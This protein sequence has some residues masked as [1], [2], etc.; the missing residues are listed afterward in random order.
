MKIAQ[1]RK[2]ILER[3]RCNILTGNQKQQWIGGNDWMVRV[4][5][6]LFLTAECVK[7]LFDLDTVQMTKLQITEAPLETYPLWPVMK[8]DMNPMKAGPVAIDEYGGVATLIFGNAVYLLER[9]YIKAAVSN[10]DYREYMLAWDEGN[11]PL[12]VICDGMIFSGIARPMS[13]DVCKLT[14]EQMRHMSALEP[15]GTRAPHENGP[16]K[17]EAEG[18]IQMDMT[19]FQGGDGDDGQDQDRP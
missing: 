11:N 7:G 16:L 1:I 14:M 15:G 12:I 18:G 3:W 13:A 8:R 4:D 17:L 9:K 10:D 2:L 5:E 6:G 19:D